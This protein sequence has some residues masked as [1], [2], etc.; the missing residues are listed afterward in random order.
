MSNPSTDRPRPQRLRFGRKLRSETP[1][2]IYLLLVLGLVLTGVG[3]WMQAI[4]DV[5]GPVQIEHPLDQGRQP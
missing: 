1:M 5:P 4:P 2:H 3:R